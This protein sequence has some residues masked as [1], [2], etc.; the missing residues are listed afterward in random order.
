MGLGHPQRST[1]MT[2]SPERAFSIIS[3]I[4]RFPALPVLDQLMVIRRSCC[5]RGQ[6]A[7]Y[8]VSLR[9][10]CSPELSLA[11]VSANKTVMVS[12]LNATHEATIA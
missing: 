2:R 8:F 10:I 6:W 3:S 1:I 11:A 5:V 9:S 12:R 7:C 4:I